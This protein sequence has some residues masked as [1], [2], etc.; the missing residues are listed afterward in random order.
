M[1]REWKC[2]AQLKGYQG[3]D[4]CPGRLPDRSA[5]PPRRGSVGTP[6]RRYV[7]GMTDMSPPVTPMLGGK[8]ARIRPRTRWARLGHGVAYRDRTLAVPR[9]A[10]QDRTQESTM[11]LVHDPDRRPRASRGTSICEKDPE[12]TTPGGGW[13]T[14]ELDWPAGSQPGRL[15]SMAAALASGGGTHLSSHLLVMVV[16]R[17]PTRGFCG[18]ARGPRP[19][20]LACGVRDSAPCSRHGGGGADRARARPT[21]PE[22]GRRMCGVT[23]SQPP[24]LAVPCALRRRSTY[25]DPLLRQRER[26][27]WRMPFGFPG[28]NLHVHRRPAAKQSL[29]VLRLNLV[30]PGATAV[31]EGALTRGPRR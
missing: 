10:A 14:F 25:R 27:P 31:G 4:A 2:Q 13:D 1:E 15:S 3:V 12:D 26:A 16:S 19:A 28:R 17:T 24:L 11:T 7:G 9:K 20:E 29:A 6:V 8:R 5:S 22:A 23:R 30:V 18:P 21:P